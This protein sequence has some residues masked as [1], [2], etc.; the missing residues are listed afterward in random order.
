MALFFASSSGGFYDDAIHGEHMP[1]DAVEITRARYESLLSEQAAGKLITA[2][3]AGHPI[4][5][6]RPALAPQVPSQV[7]QRQAHLALLE[8]GLLDD[9]E[10]LIAGISDPI[11][12]RRAEI[13]WKAPTY[14]R[15]SPFLQQLAA[16]LGLTP[17]RLDELFIQA[18]QL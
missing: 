4:A 13:E 6:V 2:D 11:E 17:G 15:G 1:A 14:E 9:A 3:A 16:Q 7:S 8:V 18:G 10:A 5:T 12:R